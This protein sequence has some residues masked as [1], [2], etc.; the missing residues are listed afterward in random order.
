[1]N[2]TEFIFTSSK[3]RKMI[4]QLRRE[5]EQRDREEL[6]ELRRKSLEIDRDIIETDKEIL[7]ILKGMT[8]TI[9]AKS[10]QESEK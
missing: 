8:A 5:Q 9:A 2:F 1:M 7:G 3:K 10:R 6:Q 4:E